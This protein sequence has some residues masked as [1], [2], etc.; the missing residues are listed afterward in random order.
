MSKH[1]AAKL[2]IIAK[3]F[4]KDG[5]VLRYDVCDIIIAVDENHQVSRI[6]QHISNVKHSSNQK[7]KIGSSSRQLFLADSVQKLRHMTNICVGIYF[8]FHLSNQI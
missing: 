7:R 4:Q 1:T 8:L 5:I 3:D 6:K 2:Q